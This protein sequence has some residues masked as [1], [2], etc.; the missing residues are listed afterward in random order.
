M[1][2]SFLFG[3]IEAVISGPLPD[4]P[5]IASGASGY[6]RFRNINIGNSSSFYCTST[7][8]I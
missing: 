5:I 3:L 2:S 1:Q 7:S 8:I 4:S 6:F